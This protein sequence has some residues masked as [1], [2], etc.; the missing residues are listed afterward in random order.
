VA[1]ARALASEPD[2]LVCDEVTSASDSQTAEAITDLLAQLRTERGIAL[3]VISHGLALIAQNTDR[4]LVMDEGRIVEAGYT[5]DVLRAPDHPAT[6]DLVAAS[7]LVGHQ[8]SEATSARSRG[9]LEGGSRRAEQRNHSGRS[10]IDAA[11]E[12][13]RIDA[14]TLR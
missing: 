13:T 10:C 8:G 3:M 11:E 7:E 5:A 12:T 14:P 6:A 9:P 4:S 2:I 1:I